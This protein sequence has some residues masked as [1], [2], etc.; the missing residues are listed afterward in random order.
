MS[1]IVISRAITGSVHTRRLPRDVVAFGVERREATFVKLAVNT[2]NAAAPAFYSSLGFRRAMRHR[3]F[4]LSGRR[5][6][7]GVR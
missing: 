5:F 7:E 4:S 6:G 1:R 2:D 3:T